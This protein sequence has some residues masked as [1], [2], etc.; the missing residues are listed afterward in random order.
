MC[1]LLRLLLLEGPLHAFI[2]D[3][4][5]M[6][7]TCFSPLSVPQPLLWFPFPKCQQPLSSLDLWPEGGLS[8]VQIIFFTGSQLSCL[9]RGTLRS[10]ANLV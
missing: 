4:T 2:S 10:E 3:V 6:M 9:G 7:I 8:V 5:I 1:G